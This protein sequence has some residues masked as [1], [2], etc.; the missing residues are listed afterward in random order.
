MSKRYDVVVIGGRLSAVVTGALL[1][2]RELRGLLVDQGELGSVGSFELDDFPVVS[3]ASRVRDWVH[4][5]L[6]LKDDFNRL[7]PIDPLLQVILPDARF[8]VVGAPA[9]AQAQRSEWS[10]GLGL[11]PSAVHAAF[12]ALAEVD[13]RLDRFLLETPEIPITSSLF[14]RRSDQS[15]A[16]RTP[17][18]AQTLDASSLAGRIPAPLLD[19]LQGMLPFCTH[20]DLRDPAERTLGRWVR[21]VL[22]LLRGLSHVGPGRS[23]RSLLLELAERK[24]MEVRRTA[25][26]RMVPRGKSWELYLAGSKEPVLTDIVVDASTDLSGL[27]TIPAKHQGRQLPLIQQAG[28]PR[29]QLYAIGFEVDRNVLPPGM[30]THLLLLNGRRDPSR[31]DPS[32]PDGEDRPIWLTR[33]PG[34]EAHRIQLVSTHPVSSVQAHGGRKTP[35]EE[36]IRARIHRLLPFLSEGNPEAFA[37]E[38][39][40][41]GGGFSAHPFFEP[42]G[43]DLSCLGGIS[44]RTPFKNVYLAGPAVIP[45]LGAEAEYLAALQVADAVEGLATGRKVSRSLAVT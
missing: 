6:G 26:E 11:D 39:G 9:D 36:V 12:E 33:R 32:D 24:A 37:V 14:S 38:S 25:V 41:F 4:E 17:E 5:S 16:K 3:G 29:G 30:A 40:R 22:R 42:G 15:A 20:L 28:K 23:D 13:E 44:M 31:F 18:L 45:S 1:A 35:L 21:P 27:D 43:E 2:K 7:E 8:D 19:V 34:R 10:D